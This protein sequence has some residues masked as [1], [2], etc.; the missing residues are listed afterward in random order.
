MNFKED[1]MKKLD[2]KTIQELKISDL[3][4]MEI[5]EIS[6]MELEDLKEILVKIE[7]AIKTKKES[8]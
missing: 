4:E 7:T 5:Q 1:K 8:E 3:K 6:E 2:N